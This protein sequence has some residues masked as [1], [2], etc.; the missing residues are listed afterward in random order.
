MNE[1]FL[2]HVWKY[3]LFNNMVLQTLAGEEVHVLKPGEQNPDSGPDFFNA[4]IRIGQTEW[5]GNV[6]IDLTSADWFHHGHHTN[7]AFSK[8]I[9]HVV[10][11]INKPLTHGIPVVEL[12]KYMDTTTLQHYEQLQQSKEGIP[13][14]KSLSR[15][16][17]IT[18]QTWLERMVVER[19][20]QKSQT[21]EQALEN[22]KGDWE[23]TF[24]HLLARNFGFKTNTVPF[25]LLAKS[26]PPSALAK[27]KNNLLQLE[28]LLFGQAG[29]LS[30]NTGDDYYIQLKQEYKHLAS[31]FT[32]SPLEKTLWK[33][34][35]MR[36]VNFPSVR[37]AQFAALIHHSSHLF[38][39]I[40]EV[41]EVQQLYKLFAA[42]P[43][44]YWTT[45]YHFSKKSK[46]QIKSLGQS[47]ID[48]ILINTIAPFLLVYGKLKNSEKYRQRALSLLQQCKAEN[49]SIISL[50]KA[51]GIKP[52][53][54]WHT[55]GL[56]QLK[57][58]YCNS[59]QCL[60][61]AIGIKILKQ[62]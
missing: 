34:A 9:L 50:W 57:N 43:S 7:K 45:H 37:I 53:H 22:N 49:N 20:E 39:K 13:C 58:Q 18:I 17:D 38:S 16:P 23:T 6:E 59:R 31:K 24:Y 40:I 14:S 29:F 1:A 51:A 56:I 4:R 8:I 25:E 27:H 33:F 62:K 55:Q 26:L 28:A 30:D 5:A 21:M 42:K 12:K 52:E 41:D 32:L 36:P 60:K 35:R 47:S 3:R 48:N 19:L 61:C 11:E 10:Y 44:A 15:V 2:Y 54:A 46:E